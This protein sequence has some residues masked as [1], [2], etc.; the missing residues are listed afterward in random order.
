MRIRGQIIHFAGI[1][2][3]NEDKLIIIKDRFDDVLR[4]AID[5]ILNG[6]K[7]IFEGDFNGRIGKQ[8]DCLIVGMLREV[9]IKDKVECPLK[10]SD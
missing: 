9:Y 5:Q 10:I 1:Y 3:S 8:N 7:I 6:Q 4:E 2:A